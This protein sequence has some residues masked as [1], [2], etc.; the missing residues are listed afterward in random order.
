MKTLCK[1]RLYIS[2]LIAGIV[3]TAGIIALNYY[4]FEKVEPA[5]F[6][7]YEYGIS[8]HLKK[9]DAHNKIVDY[10]LNL[11][12]R[13]FDAHEKNWLEVSKEMLLL[14]PIDKSLTL[15]KTVGVIA[16][17]QVKLD[18]TIIKELNAI[19]GRRK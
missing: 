6:I 9:K 1:Y 8:L 3:I 4:D 12:K 15:S 11:T 18:E 16:Y 19:Y 10:R 5:G 2:A 14:Y 7:N 13:F 17:K